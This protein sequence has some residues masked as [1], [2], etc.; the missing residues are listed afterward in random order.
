MQPA[1]FEI[2][3]VLPSDVRLTE[4]MRDLAAHAA[5]YAGCGEGQ[6]AAYG[7]AVAAVVL[8][9]LERTAPGGDVPVIVRRGAGPVE[10]LIA[11]EER[12]EA[13]TPHD[14]ITVGWTRERSGWMCRVALDLQDC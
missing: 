1:D 5:R 4:A 13:N 9:C 2:N 6:A 7:D 8:A 14:Q 12:F 11:C 3:V 10:C